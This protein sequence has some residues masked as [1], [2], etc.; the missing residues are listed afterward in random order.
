[1][2]LFQFANINYLYGLAIV[3]LLVILLWIGNIIRKRSVKKF[4]DPEVISVLMDDASPSRPIAKY[5]ILTIAL[6]ALIIGI[7]GPQV[8][9]KLEEMKRKGVEL[10]IALDVSNS[11]LAEDIK[12]NRLER[13]KQA[14]SN[15]VDEL[16]SDRIGL[17]VFAG[18][19]YVQL[20]ITTDYAAAKMILSTIDTKI[21]PTQGTAIG[22]A[23]EMASK[24]FTS[25]EGKN[26]AII[27][28]TDGE[29]HEDDAIPSAQ[30]AFENG[31][32]VYTIGMG[33]PE[34]VP[35]PLNNRSSGNFRTDRQGQIVLTKL[36]ETMLSQIAA[37]GGGKYI[38]ANNTKTGLKELFQEINKLEKVK[39]ETSLYAEYEDRY[40]YLIGI[41]I[42]LLLLEFIIL[43]RKNRYF[44]NINLFEGK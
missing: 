20:P 28:I 30:S 15:L 34:G 14:I 41:A 27:V 44:K 12:P 23:I 26:R 36:D 21:V 1:M 43:S 17:I 10:V 18:D 6:S 11:M 32:V 16:N 8:G 40:Q 29:N 13:A 9:S 4:G 38:R 42:F 22:A 31:I 25:E 5:L 35:I 3:P 19:A 7:A 2:E 24:S 33:L 37:E 39:M